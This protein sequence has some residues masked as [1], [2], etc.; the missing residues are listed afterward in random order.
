MTRWSK[1]ALITIALFCFSAPCG[2]ARADEVLKYRLFLHSTF[3]QSQE[4]GDVDGHTVSLVRFSGLASFPDGTVG[5]AYFVGGLDYTKGAGPFSVYYN[6]TLND[7]SVL[8]YKGTGTAAVD[9]TKTVFNGNV[10]VL[11]GKGLFEGAKGDGTYTG[12]RI[13]ADLYADYTINIKK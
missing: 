8:W 6:V 5:T 3:A 9:G 7:G 1:L 2:G 13:G 11:G 10:M 12:T 4:V